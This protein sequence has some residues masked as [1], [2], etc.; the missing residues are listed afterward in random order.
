M[1]Y[2]PKYNVKRYEWDKENVRMVSLKLQ[3]TTDADIIA[4]LEAGEN[5]SGEAKRLIRY[6]IENG[7]R[8]EK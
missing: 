5:M 2:N 7:G 1:P 3:Y 4:A 6:A 8:R